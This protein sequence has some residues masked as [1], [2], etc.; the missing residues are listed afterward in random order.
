MVF[1]FGRLP[2]ELKQQ[3]VR[4]TLLDPDKHDDNETSKSSYA[5]FRVCREIRLLVAPH[6]FK[7]SARKLPRFGRMYRY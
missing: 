3:I 4:D 1:P 5:L 6:L 7:V 2:N